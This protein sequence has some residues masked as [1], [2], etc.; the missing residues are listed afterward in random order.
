ME[1]SKNGVFEGI[2]HNTDVGSFVAN[3]RIQSK[4]FLQE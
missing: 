3:M 4:K 1:Q 2:S